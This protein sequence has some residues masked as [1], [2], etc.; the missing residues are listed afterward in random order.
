[1]SVLFLAV[2]SSS[3]K[4][5]DRS[6]P[7][8][9][10]YWSSSRG[11]STALCDEIGDAF[12]QIRLFWLDLEST[13]GRWNRHYEGWKVN[14]S[15]DILKPESV[16]ICQDQDA[17]TLED[18]YRSPKSNKKIILSEASCRNFTNEEAKKIVS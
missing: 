14:L 6:V 12:A 7:C 11:S 10:G 17:K 5:F 15:M 16:G 3:V 4:R 1:M 9:K 8:F 13:C 2:F 18:D